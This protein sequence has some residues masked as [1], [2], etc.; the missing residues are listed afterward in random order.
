MFYALGDHQID[1][2]Q[3]ELSIFNFAFLQLIFLQSINLVFYLLS[4]L[5]RNLFYRDVRFANFG[6][7]C[8]VNHL[9][10]PLR[11]NMFTCTSSKGHGLWFLIGGFRSVPFVSCFKAR[12]FVIVLFRAI[13]DELSL[14]L[15]FSDLSYSNVTCKN[16]ATSR[17]FLW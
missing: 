7:F 8:S 1:L 10:G 11:K 9:S 16:K 2:L 6:L 15:R 3:F 12:C 14:L 13:I 5:Q 4:I 17:S